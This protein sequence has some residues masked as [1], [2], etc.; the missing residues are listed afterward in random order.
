MLRASSLQSS[1]ELKDMLK[2]YESPEMDVI[3]L[4]NRDV[5]V[6]SD[7][8]GDNGRDPSDYE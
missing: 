7:L 6:S 1:R 8:V 2:K 5:I 3:E 4:E